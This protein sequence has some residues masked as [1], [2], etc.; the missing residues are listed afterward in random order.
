ME[1]YNKVAVTIRGMKYPI[2]TRED[3]AYVVGLAHKLDEALKELTQGAGAVSLNE[4][5]I[6]SFADGVE[7]LVVIEDLEP[8]IEDAVKAMGITCSGKD[9]TGAQ[10]ELFARKIAALYGGKAAPGPM[11]T[12]DIPMRPPVMCAGCPH[13]ALYYVINKLKLT[14]CSDIGCYSL[15]ALP[16]L[17]ALDTVVCM[18]AAIGMAH[19]MEKAMNLSKDKVAVI[20][21]STFCHSG[22]TGLLNMVYN[23]SQGTVI[24]ADNSITGMTGH[25]D[26]PSTGRDL[27]GNTAPQLDLVALVKALGVEHVS[28]A[29]PFCLKEFETLLKTETAR[30]RLSVIIAKRPC[31]LIVKQPGTAYSC[32]LTKCKDCGLCLKLGCPAIVKQEKGV[33]V[34]ATQCVGCALCEGVCPFGALCKE[35]N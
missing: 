13:R 5:L 26:N 27:Y 25:Q 8:F 22:I 19:G 29:D 24:I 9:K 21:D 32:D 10:G 4:A 12:Q 3:P 33:K 34:D 1:L 23:S 20:G 7:E 35:E 31:A 16:P 14:V 18:G 6:R 15:G 11:T 28:V 30:D 17:N 2:T